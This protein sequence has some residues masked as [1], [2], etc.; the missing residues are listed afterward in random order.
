MLIYCTTV[1]N[2]IPRLWISIYRQVLH[3]GMWNFVSADKPNGAL[4]TETKFHI[5]NYD[6]LENMKIRSRAFE[7]TLGSSTDPNLGHNH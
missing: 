6:S 7:V 3:F 4:S 2:L 5:Q 1:N